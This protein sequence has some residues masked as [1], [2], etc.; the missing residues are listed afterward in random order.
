[1][2]SVPLVHSGLHTAVTGRFSTHRDQEVLFHG[3][4]IIVFTLL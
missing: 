1:M 4:A 2:M 3:L